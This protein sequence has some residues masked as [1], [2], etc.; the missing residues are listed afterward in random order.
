MEKYSYCRELLHLF[1][2]A[3]GRTQWG[4]TKPVVFSSSIHSV[5]ITLC[6][7]T[8]HIY[9][10]MQISPLWLLPI[11]MPTLNVPSNIYW[12]SAF[13][14]C[15]AVSLHVSLTTGRQCW[16]IAEKKGF[17]GIGRYQYGHSKSRSIEVLRSTVGMHRICTWKRRPLKHFTA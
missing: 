9:I 8:V 6:L 3:G 2:A 14:V 16:S 1:L 12:E 11:V 4:S 7:P 15:I 5:A 17:Q 10:F 13:Y